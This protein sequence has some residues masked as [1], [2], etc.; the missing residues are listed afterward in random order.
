MRLLKST[1]NRKP[2]GG[3]LGALRQLL[4]SRRPRVRIRLRP[5]EE[6]PLT[7]ASTSHPSANLAVPSPFHDNSPTAGAVKNYSAQTVGPAI[8]APPRDP[9]ADDSDDESALED[10][11]SGDHHEHGNA[12]RSDEEDHHKEKLEKNR[13]KKKAKRG[14]TNSAWVA[15]LLN[16]AAPHKDRVHARKKRKPRAEDPAASKSTSCHPLLCIVSDPHAALLAR[17]FDFLPRLEPGRHCALVNRAIAV[18][19]DRYYARYCD[20]PRPRAFL[21]HKIFSLRHAETTGLLKAVLGMLPLTDRVRASAT[22]HL[23]RCAADSLPLDFAQSHHASKF[24]GRLEASRVET[25]FQQTTV[26]RCGK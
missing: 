1:D 7:L 14:R 9:E 12:G 17:V 2:G 16:Q 15:K 19:V 4:L 11:G 20:W 3:V 18:S 6:T 13:K 25:R 26:L 10:D 24:L 22:S 8:P 23:F 5:R 21:A